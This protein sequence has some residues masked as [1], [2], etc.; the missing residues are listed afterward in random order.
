MKSRITGLRQRPLIATLAGNLGKR[1]ADFAYYPDKDAQYFTVENTSAVVKGAEPSLSSVEDKDAII[2]DPWGDYIGDFNIMDLPPLFE[3][4]DYSEKR[5]FSNGVQVPCSRYHLEGVI[6]DRNALFTTDGKSLIG[7]DPH[8]R[9]LE[10]FFFP[11]DIC[12]A[13]KKLWDKRSSIRLYLAAFT[14]PKRGASE[15][16]VAVRHT[17]LF[18]G[19]ELLQYSVDRQPI[20]N[21]RNIVTPTFSLE[22]PF[23]IELDKCLLDKD[24]DTILFSRG[25]SGGDKTRITTFT[26]I[27]GIARRDKNDIISDFDSDGNDMFELGVEVGFSGS[28]VDIMKKFV[29]KKLGL[30]FIHGRGWG[31]DF[32]AWDGRWHVAIMPLDAERVRVDFAD[33]VKKGKI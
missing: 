21:Y 23:Q 2:P 32:H 14:I 33:A 20:P 30:Y 27:L 5:K 16:I 12:K 17:I 8:T 3:M 29:M 15:D 11:T 25:S 4:S 31:R 1:E 22:L 10:T 9:G 19:Q 28:C 18:N 26:D 13:L 7:W 6:Y 24:F